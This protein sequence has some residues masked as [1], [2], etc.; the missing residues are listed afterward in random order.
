MKTVQEITATMTVND[1]IRAAPAT[2]AVFNEAGIDSCCGGALTIGEA[3][4][5]H[6]LDVEALLEKLRRA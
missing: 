4:R 2:V 6:G 3:A 1:A 5:R